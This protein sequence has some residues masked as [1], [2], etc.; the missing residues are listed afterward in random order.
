[1]AE[2]WLWTLN[3]SPAYIG[4]GIIMGPATTLPMLLGAI[5][6]WGILSPLAKRE[7]W[8]P[9][10][11]S[12]WDAGSR[13]WIAWIALVI[14]LSDA[15]MN[16]CWFAVRSILRSAPGMQSRIIQMSS[17]G[18]PSNILVPFRMSRQTYAPISRSASSASVASSPP[19]VHR[20]SDNILEDAPPQHLISNT[21]L[22]VMFI[23]SLVACVI[24]IQVSFGSIIP[25]QLSILAVVIAVLL[26]IMGVRAVGE[27]D[28]NPASGIS[29]FTQ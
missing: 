24:S 6:G 22:L 7:E 9:G 27:T 1:M 16:L 10:P 11:T 13:G 14:M 18:L 15:L 5:I 3:P 21:A 23:L 28:I 4:Q 2:I 20:P 17:H 12:D 26:S 29:K 19:S 8:A 25:P